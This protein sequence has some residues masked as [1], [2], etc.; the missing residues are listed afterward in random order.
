MEGTGMKH[1]L[2]PPPLP[3]RR[4]CEDYVDWIG[5]DKEA[6]N[7]L[8][9]LTGTRYS[10]QT[11]YNWANKGHLKTNGYRPLKTTRKLLRECAQNYL[12]VRLKR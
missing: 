4:R 6:L 12:G 7:F 10:R 1:K 8:E 3:E 5:L 2:P 11:L 9:V